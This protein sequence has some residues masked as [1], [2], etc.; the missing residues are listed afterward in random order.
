MEDAAKLMVVPSQTGPFDETVGA[1][2][3]GYT[4]IPIVPAGPLQPLTMAFTE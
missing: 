1:D 3:M 2:G 4:V